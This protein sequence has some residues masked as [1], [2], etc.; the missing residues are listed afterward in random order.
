MVSHT[1]H[2]K[3]MVFSGTISGTTKNDHP[4][5]WRQGSPV[6]EHFTTK[7]GTSIKNTLW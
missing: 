1:V 4:C 2:E 7:N 5:R 6:S 3:M